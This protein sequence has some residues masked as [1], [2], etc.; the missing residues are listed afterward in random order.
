MSSSSTCGRDSQSHS[1]DTSL[2]RRTARFPR[3]WQGRWRRSPR[4]DSGVWCV[5]ARRAWRARCQFGCESGL[6]LAQVLRKPSLA[7]HFSR[8]YF[9][10]EAD[11]RVG[12]RPLP[13]HKYRANDMFHIQMC[14][15][16]AHS[17]RQSFHALTCMFPDDTVRVMYSARCIF[18]MATWC[19]PNVNLNA[20][21]QG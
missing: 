18:D 3:S 19:E 1:D 4:T 10:S 15:V 21:V 11:D 7:Q 20:S 9:G 13:R 16:L 5:G 14:F 8:R 6:Y 2:L 12:N 17:A